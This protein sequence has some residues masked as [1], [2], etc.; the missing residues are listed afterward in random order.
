VQITP[1]GTLGGLT[2]VA[3]GVDL[4]LASQTCPTVGP[5][6]A[7]CTFTFNFK[8][9]T[10]GAKTESVICSSGGKT[11]Q[12]TVAATVVTPASLS[13]SPATVAMSALVG[14]TTT[15]TL[16]VANAGGSPSG[17]P[18]V[19]ISGDSNFVVASNDCVVPL[20]PLAY[21]KVQVAFTPATAGTHTAKLTVSESQ[22]TVPAT[23]ALTGYAVAMDGGVADAAFGE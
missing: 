13:I 3:N 11:T 23:A 1:T 16:M 19:A 21:C 9:A 5:V 10:A 15:V 12:T 4:A 20:A 14:Q 17:L 7:A 8:S 6:S 2:C 22:D 18:I